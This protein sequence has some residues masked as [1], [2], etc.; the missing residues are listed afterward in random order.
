[1]DS[2]N[3]SSSGNR[4]RV[5][6]GNSAAKLAAECG[7][8]STKKIGPSTTDLNRCAVRIQAITEL[9]FTELA[10]TELA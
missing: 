4:K 8:P 7:W 1:L 10:F 3:I 5:D 6:S 2:T 9:A